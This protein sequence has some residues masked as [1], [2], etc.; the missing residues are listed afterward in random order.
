VHNNLA[1]ILR[2]QNRTVEAE[3]F[4][5]K[6]LEMDPD[7]TSALALRAEFEADKGHFP[8][9]GALYRRAT[10][11]DPNF[12]QAW[13]G[14]AGLRKMTPD[15]APWLKEAQ[16][17]VG[18]RLPLREKIQLRYAIGKYF[19][20]LRDYPA[21]FTNFQ[22]ANEL[23]KQITPRYDAVQSE[24][25]FKV[26]ADFYEMRRIAE[27]RPS[28]EV[29]ARPVFIGPSPPRPTSHPSPIRINARPCGAN[30]RAVTLVFLKAY[31]ATLNASLTRCRP[32]F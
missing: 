29:S 15:D 8:E 2:S 14:L 27:A 24:K 31:R 17:V 32:I 5:L 6:A 9:A 13:A 12:A 19:D 3:A 22:R 18:N 20:D 7:L 26:T 16:R 21:A 30:W 4:C 25:Q 1:V 23:T 10:S 28:A 11:I